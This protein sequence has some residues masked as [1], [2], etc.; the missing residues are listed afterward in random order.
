MEKNKKTKICSSKIKFQI[1]FFL[2]KHPSVFQQYCS[3]YPKDAQV[4]FINIYGQSI[5]LFYFC[6]FMQS[7]DSICSCPIL[8]LFYFSQAKCFKQAKMAHL[9]LFHILIL[10]QKKYRK[11]YNECFSIL[12]H[13]ASLWFKFSSSQ[14]F[15]LF[16]FFFF[17]NQWIEYLSVL[18]I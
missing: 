13:A 17:K 9:C 18:F 8:P 11:Q 7:F 12:P 5:I 15:L 16:F 3:Q 4:I 6:C 2:C 10:K 1:F 14:S